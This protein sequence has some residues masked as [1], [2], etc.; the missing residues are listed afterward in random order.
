MEDANPI[1]FE[2]LNPSGVNEY[3]SVLNL[4]H[5]KEADQGRFQCIISNEFGVTYSKK[6]RVTV[7][8]EYLVP[9]TSVF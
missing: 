9:N 6:A 5:I 2:R 4:P 1:Y 7:H 3:T 8:S